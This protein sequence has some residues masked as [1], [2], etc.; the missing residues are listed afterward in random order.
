MSF[1]GRILRQWHI[2]PVSMICISFSLHMMAVLTLK[3]YRAARGSF[4]VHCRNMYQGLNK[5][6][7]ADT[8]RFTVCPS[9][10]LWFIPGA[11]QWANCVTS[12]QHYAVCVCLPVQ[13]L[14]CSRYIMWCHW[15]YVTS[16]TPW[17]NLAWYHTSITHGVHQSHIQLLYGLL[18]KSDAG[19]DG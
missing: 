6:V 9:C 7:L 12:L 15:L 8:F 18:Q 1:R 10:L 17:Q 11:L 14:R 3:T 4:E 16:G 19:S 13:D 5:G 2:V